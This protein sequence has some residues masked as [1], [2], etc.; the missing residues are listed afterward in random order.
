MKFVHILGAGGMY[1]K[2]Y[3]KMLIDYFDTKDH[4]FITGKPE[5][6]NYEYAR[7]HG[8][9][10]YKTVS[11][12]AI[13]CL[14]DCDYIIAHGMINPK[15]LML[16]YLWP[17]LL[18]KTNWVIWGGDI[19]DNANPKENFRAR[20]IS[21][22]RCSV[23]PKV[24]WATSLSR[25]DFAYAHERYGLMAFEFEGCYPV[26]ASTNPEL[27]AKLRPIK[28]DKRDS[29]VH[30]V[31]V[32]NS[33]TLSN[34]H[35]GALDMLSKYRDRNIQIFMPLN[36]GPEGY[37]QYASDVIAYAESIFGKEKVVALR[38]RVDGPTYL[39][40]LSKVDV[41]VFNNNRQQAMG[42]I[43]QLLLLGA[44]IYIRSD[45]SMWSHFESLGCLLDSFESIETQSFDELIEYESDRREANVSIIE[46]RH[47]I[48]EKVRAWRAIFAGMEAGAR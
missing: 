19:Y 17:S 8:C 4:C 6:Q 25:R 14:H 11:V 33:A 35:M 2:D 40:F 1:T 45:V 43:S 7:E 29:S 21:K 20:L 9:P 31:Q 16:F 22:M 46:K 44:K 28:D 42:N 30:V 34:Q 48:E 5:H 18:K 26:P 32:G 13:R 27:M 37:E 38:D 24:R 23:Y 15:V 36:Y 10:I 12:A 39:E 3:C 47:A 41:G